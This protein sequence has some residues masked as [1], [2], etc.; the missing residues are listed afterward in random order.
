MKHWVL[1]LQVFVYIEIREF[2]WTLERWLHNSL[3]ENPF[4]DLGKCNHYCGEL[5]GIKAFQSPPT[6]FRAE[7]AAHTADRHHKNVNEVHICI[8]EIKMLRQQATHRARA[9]TL[10]DKVHAEH[11]RTRECNGNALENTLCDANK[12]SLKYLRNYYTSY[13]KVMVHF[14]L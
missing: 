4:L 9:R 8:N 2:F 6:A 13:Y 11:T 5:A 1:T 10:R 14:V 3:K 12:L 7:H